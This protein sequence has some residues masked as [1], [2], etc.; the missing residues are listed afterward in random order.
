[1]AK[2]NITEKK[3]NPAGIKVIASPGVMNELKRRILDVVVVK[4]KYKDKDYSA[5]LL[6]KDICTNTRYLSAALN[7]C[8]NSNYSSFI[9]N[10]RVEEAKSMLVDSR[11]QNLRMEEISDAVGFSNRQSFYASF[12]RV[13]GMTPREYRKQNYN[14]HNEHNR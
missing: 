12:Y 14:K 7:L 1:M 3:D 13:T 5:K 2:Y 4:K 10:Y 11:Y 8:F 6:A 9:N